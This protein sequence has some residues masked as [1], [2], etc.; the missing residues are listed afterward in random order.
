MKSPW[1][2]SSQQRWIK[3]FN[4]GIPTKKKNW[5]LKIK[6]LQREMWRLGFIAAQN[7]PVSTNYHVQLLFYNHEIST[8]WPQVKY[9]NVFSQVLCDFSRQYSPKSKYLTNVLLVCIQKP[10]W[11]HLSFTRPWC[12]GSNIQRIHCTTE[13]HTYTHSKG[14]KRFHYTN[15]KRFKN[16]LLHCGSTCFQCDARSPQRWHRGE[17]ERSGVRLQLFILYQKHGWTLTLLV[18]LICVSIPLAAGFTVHWLLQ[19]YSSS[20]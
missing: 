3:H 11:L 16:K 10:K 6:K 5:S 14:N 2:I 18:Q 19:N 4:Q 13:K 17:T 7:L 12:F 1:N 8:R 9:E 20:K 15:T